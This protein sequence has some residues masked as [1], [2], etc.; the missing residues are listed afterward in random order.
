[1]GGLGISK[2]RAKQ[3]K[4]TGRELG[5]AARDAPRYIPGPK[6]TMR[7]LRGVLN[8]TTNRRVYD[9]TTILQVLELLKKDDT[10]KATYVSFPF[11]SSHGLPNTFSVNI[12]VD[13]KWTE[14]C[15]LTPQPSPTST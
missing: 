14:G 3:W 9:V 12:D 6:I 11:V 5:K 13:P 1:M 7:D 4:V 2:N 8:V 10:K 15:N